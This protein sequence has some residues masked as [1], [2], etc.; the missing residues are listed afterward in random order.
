MK[1]LKFIYPV[2]I[3]AVVFISCGDK[4]VVHDKDYY[5]QYVPNRSMHGLKGKVKEYEVVNY[6]GSQWDSEKEMVI[7][8]ESHSKSIYRFDGN[9][10]L[11]E[12]DN[13]ALNKTEDAQ[14][15]EVMVSSLKYLYD[16]LNRFAQFQ[17]FEYKDGI[18]E[19]LK[20]KE[21]YAYDNDNNKVIID[22]LSNDNSSGERQYTVVMKLDNDGRIINRYPSDIEGKQLRALKAIESEVSGISDRNTK[23]ETITKYDTKD[24]V[25]ESVELEKSEATGTDDESGMRIRSYKKMVISYYDE[26]AVEG[27]VERSGDVADARFVA[28]ILSD[29]YADQNNLVASITMDNYTGVGTGENGIDT[30]A[31]IPKERIVHKYNKK[32]VIAETQTW[33][34]YRTNQSEKATIY[35]ELKEEYGYDSKLRKTLQVT[36]KYLPN[37]DGEPRESTIKKEEITYDDADKKATHLIYTTFCES[38]SEQMKKQAYDLNNEGYIVMT[39]YTT[40]FIPPSN[41][42][43]RDV[44]KNASGNEVWYRNYD[45]ELDK[46]GN[47]TKRVFS[48]SVYNSTNKFKERIVSDY[49]TR[50]ITY[51]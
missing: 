42:S 23:Y 9:G 31:N 24:N 5:A 32:G 35:L 3:M 48:Y 25:I 22:C 8:G 39:D 34:I 16:D 30:L 17:S 51:Y 12:V 13:F 33:K 40:G 7:E 29:R 1:K 10:I 36:T 43:E 50:T 20:E 6:F 28:S 19:T 26:P 47:W 44:F 49:R 2:L 15:N 18:N 11:T 37:V 27:K 41:K 21:S 14:S 45:E 4:K 46:H 38:G